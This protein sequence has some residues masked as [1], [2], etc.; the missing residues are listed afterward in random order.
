MNKEQIVEKDLD[1]IYI[2]N[3]NTVDENLKF[4][5]KGKYGS[6]FTWETGESRFIEPDGTVHRP[7]HGMGNRKVILTVKAVYEGCVG[8]RTFTATVLQE[9]KELVITEIR[10]VSLKE[11]V[12]EEPRLPSVVIVHTAD[13]RQT[14]VP[15]HWEEPSVLTEEGSMTVEGRVGGSEKKA[16]AHIQY[17]S[18]SKV[19]EGPEIKVN[20]FHISQV[21]L[22]E[23]TLY[24]E[25]QQ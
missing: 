19:P 22:K 10:P 21:R 23:G 11:K 17:E 14:T 9:A 20:Y 6:T 7:L 1:G 25:Y 3:L 13:G 2:G 15:V 16:V 4:P 18:S 5:L 12:G 8:E 24:Q